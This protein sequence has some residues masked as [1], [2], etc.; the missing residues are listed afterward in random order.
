[1]SER[2]ST[3]LRSVGECP[4]P[5]FAGAGGTVPSIDVCTV[6]QHG[7]RAENVYRRRAFNCECQS[8]YLLGEWLSD[9]SALSVERSYVC[10]QYGSDG[11]SAQ[12]ALSTLSPVIYCEQRSAQLPPL[13]HCSRADEMSI[14]GHRPSSSAA[15]LN[16][17]QE[18]FVRYNAG[19]KSD[20]P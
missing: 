20:R 9:V 2:M 17:L 16:D 10:Q 1:M 14:V 12:Y 7:E 6:I 18:P 19:A 11:G 3:C 8:C 13:F 5:S 4:G 15:I